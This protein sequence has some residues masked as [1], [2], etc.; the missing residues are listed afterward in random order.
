M[1]DNLETFAGG[2]RWSFSDGI[3]QRLTGNTVLSGYNPTIRAFVAELDGLIPDKQ[4]FCLFWDAITFKEIDCNYF[5]HVVDG[6]SPDLLISTSSGNTVEGLARA[7]RQ[8][9]DSTGNT[10]NAILIVPEISAYKVSATAI[11]NN[12]HVKYVVLR[13]ATLDSTRAHANEL[14]AALSETRRVAV[15]SE[16]LKAAAYA[17]M[18]LLLDDAGLFDDDTCYVQAV[19]GGVGPSGIVEGAI[20]LGRKPGVLVVQPDNE[21][22]SPMVDALAEY[23]AGR[24]PVR[25]LQ[26]GNYQTSE[27]EP[28]LGSTKP[29]YTV[30]KLV[31]WKEAGGWVAGASLPQEFLMW[32]KDMILRALVNA[33]VYE[34]E[35]VGNRCF[36]REKSGFM[37]VAGAMLA[38]KSIES[39]RIVINFTGR[40]PEP[41]DPITTRFQAAVPHLSYDPAMISVDEVVEKLAE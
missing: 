32:H 10:I 14:L 3:Y 4:V 41:D 13:N 29:L 9:C 40:R 35:Q 1:Q 25:L 11:Q 34:N 19:S 31:R 12:P 6:S 23:A 38:A 7:I 8:Y 18:G 2:D 37:A 15:A 16:D 26:E 21:K 36:D 17:Q 33:G 24:D 22:Q 20:E 28:T 27:F 5:M 39:E 30:N